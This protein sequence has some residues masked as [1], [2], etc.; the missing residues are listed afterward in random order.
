MSMRGNDDQIT[1][2]LLRNGNDLLRRWADA[3]QSVRRHFAAHFLGGPLSELLLTSH[4]KVFFKLSVVESI[5]LDSL[6]VRRNNVEKAYLGT[7]LFGQRDG[8]AES[9]F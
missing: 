1:Q 8:I 3:D 9:F 4:A 2:P 6:V 5:V 7:V